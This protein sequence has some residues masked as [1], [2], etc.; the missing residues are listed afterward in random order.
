LAQNYKPV[1][2]WRW[3]IQQCVYFHSYFGAHIYNT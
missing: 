2:F 1:N 3:K